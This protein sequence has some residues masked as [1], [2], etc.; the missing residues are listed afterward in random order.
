MDY[1]KLTLA[2]ALAELNRMPHIEVEI[3]PPTKE[4]PLVTYKM[5]LWPAAFPDDGDCP[6]GA[7]YRCDPNKPDDPA[8]KRAVSKIWRSI[9]RTLFEGGADLEAYPAF[10]DEF[11]RRWDNRESAD[12]RVSHEK[13]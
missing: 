8:T 3:L 9:A 11:D 5:T 1:A 10:A 13:L 4:E 6:R 12:K 7:L 2:D